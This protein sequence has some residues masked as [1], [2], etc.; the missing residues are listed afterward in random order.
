M[1]A[2][3]DGVMAELPES[4]IAKMTTASGPAAVYDATVREEFHQELLRLI[5]RNATLPLSDASSTSPEAASMSISRATD[6]PLPIS[7]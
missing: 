3:L 7:P 1:G 2:D 4:I 5:A 6:E